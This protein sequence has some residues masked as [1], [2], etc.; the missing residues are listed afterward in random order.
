MQ[1]SAEER[2]G[3]SISVSSESRLS[4]QMAL[5][6]CDQDMG[7]EGFGASREELYFKIYGTNYGL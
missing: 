5:R 2:S 1:L 4:D 6:V 3:L 7:W